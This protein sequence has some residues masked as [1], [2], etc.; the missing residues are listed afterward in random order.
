VR[1]DQ[2]L[3]QGRFSPSTSVS[4]ANSHSTDC[5]T[6]IIYHNR[7]G[8]GRS[9]KWTQSATF[10]CVTHQLSRLHVENSPE[11]YLNW[12]RSERNQCDLN[13][14]KQRTRKGTWYCNGFCLTKPLTHC[15]FYLCCWSRPDPYASRWDQ[16]G[17]KTWALVKCAV[18]N[19]VTLLNLK[20]ERERSESITEE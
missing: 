8:I 16:P 9:T 20:T 17:L 14:R 13:A 18:S 11:R 19:D 3:R 4:P 5:S 10:V 12:L 1:Y 2:Q 7:P 6:L 15:S